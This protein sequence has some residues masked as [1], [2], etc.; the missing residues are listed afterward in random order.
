MERRGVGCETGEEG[1]DEPGKTSGHGEEFDL[2][3]KTMGNHE[4][5]RHDQ[6]C[7]LKHTGYLMEQKEFGLW[8]NIE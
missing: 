2:Y 7:V 8:E 6:N 3:P 5:E 1:R 4:R